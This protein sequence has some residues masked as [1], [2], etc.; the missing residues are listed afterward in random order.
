MNSRGVFVIFSA[1]S[2]CDPSLQKPAVI[3]FPDLAERGQGREKEAKEERERPRKRERGKGREREAK[4]KGERERE[5]GRGRERQGEGERERE[6]EREGGRER[7]GEKGR[8]GGI[9]KWAPTDSHYPGGLFGMATSLRGCCSAVWE[10]VVHNLWRQ[11]A[12]GG[13][14]PPLL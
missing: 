13:I 11:G 7:E 10:D 5:T 9:S 14:M 2:L 4:R 12:R 3:T 1:P 8:G 6:R